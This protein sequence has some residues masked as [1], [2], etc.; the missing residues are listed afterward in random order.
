MN[1]REQLIKEFR[2]FLSYNPSTGI[3]TWIA[4]TPHR[5]RIG[6]VAGYPSDKGYINITLGRKTYKA[7]RLAWLLEYGKWPDADTDHINGDRADNRIENLRDVT[8][9]VNLQNRHSAQPNN[10]S[11]FLGVDKI[12]KNCWRAQLTFGGTCVSLGCFKSPELAHS[13]YLEAK[14]K[15]HEGCSI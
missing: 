11:G 2:R 13:A 4:D 12:S 10:K 1:E 5:K 9:S 15:H 6:T 14:R 7:H 8:R 3:F